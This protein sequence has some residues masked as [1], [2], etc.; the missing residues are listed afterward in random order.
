[1]LNIIN[2]DASDKM[3]AIVTKTKKITKL[4]KKNVY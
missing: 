3:W 2:V 1:M 4:D